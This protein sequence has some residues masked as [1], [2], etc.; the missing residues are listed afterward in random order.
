MTTQTATQN[1]NDNHNNNSTPP[2][3]KKIILKNIQCYKDAEI[4]PAPP[5]EMTVLIGE[6]DRGKTTLGA[7]SELKLGFDAYSTKKMIRRGTKKGHISYVYDTPDNLTVS[8]C[9][10]CPV[11]RVSKK[12]NP[13]KAKT[14]YEIARDME[15][16]DSKGNQNREIVKLEGGGK[17]V[18]EAIQSI[19]GMRPVQI[20]KEKINFN[21]SEQLAG[22]FMGGKTTPN[23]RYRMLGILAG[24]LEV[25]QAVKEVGTEIIRARRKDTELENEIKGL[26]EQV[27]GYDWL[28]VL[29]AD[30]RKVEAALSRMREKR[31]LRD[32]LVELKE[33]IEKEKLRRLE[34]IYAVKL[35]SD[36]ISKIGAGVGQ[37]ESAADLRQKLTTA[38]INIAAQRETISRAEAILNQTQSVAALQSTLPGVEL[39]N[40][41]FRGLVNLSRQIAAD[42]GVLAEAER[43][44]NLTVAAPEIAGRVSALSGKQT[45]HTA[46]KTLKINI[47]SETKKLTLAQ[48]ILTTTQTHKMASEACERLSRSNHTKSLLLPL[49]AG[50]AKAMRDINGYSEIVERLAGVEDIRTG[51][52]WLLESTEELKIMRNAARE[53]AVLEAARGRAETVLRNTA[54]LE[55]GKEKLN[56]LQNTLSLR[57]QLGIQRGQIF[58]IELSIG[59]SSEKVDSLNSQINVARAEYRD[60]L[61]KAGICEGCK[62]VDAVMAAS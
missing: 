60:L 41:T 11:D 19:T 26:D 7:R 17:G 48:K 45:T 1:Q 23:E 18:P 54:G 10:E 51:I 2:P 9:F 28:E 36:R 47:Q 42:K 50:I 6:S 55:Q 40:T 35:F 56:G 44:I 8:W 52:A 34:M 15:D 49:Q 37:M 22:P 43:V 61:L 21:V 25:D 46:L 62:V 32:R 14:W 30:I 57:H 5:G 16:V 13:D 31:E 24:T 29:G 4:E 3:I 39:K 12:P 27:A 38:H 58:I 33:G 20:G 59:G 53:I